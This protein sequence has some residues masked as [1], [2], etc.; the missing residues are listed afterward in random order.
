MS[1]DAD[2]INAYRDQLAKIRAAMKAFGGVYRHFDTSAQRE[3]FM[4]LDDAVESTEVDDLENMY[5]SS[6]PVI[7]LPDGPHSEQSDTA[8]GHTAHIRYDVI[9]GPSPEYQRG[10]LSGRMGIYAVVKLVDD[11]P[12][13]IMRVF[14]GHPSSQSRQDAYA[15]ARKLNNEYRV[16]IGK[17][18][19]EG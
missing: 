12:P 19:W 13:E 18:P 1:Y 9:S 16:S 15:Y 4:A 14:D 6:D 5:N 11:L 3:A 10:D 7:Q 17:E 8:S 2:L